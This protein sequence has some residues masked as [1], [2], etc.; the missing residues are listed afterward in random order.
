MANSK[1]G[2]S[3]VFVVAI[4][5][6]QTHNLLAKACGGGPR[7]RRPASAANTLAAGNK[8][9]PLPG[10]TFEC[11]LS[12]GADGRASRGSSFIVS[13]TAVGRCQCAPVRL[14]LGLTT[15]N[16]AGA[17]ATGN[18]TIA[19]RVLDG[20]PA[21]S[22]AHPDQ[23]GQ[24]GEFVLLFDPGTYRQV[25]AAG[26]SPGR[27]RFYTPDTDLCT[28]WARGRGAIRAGHSRD[29]A[30]LRATPGPGSVSVRLALFGH[31]QSRTTCWRVQFTI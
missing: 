9:R 7:W 15:S 24:L 17:G 26:A 11:H 16:P 12:T 20:G 23:A 10:A 30:H 21:E 18:K 14:R 3:V 28:V 29:C 2:T 25:G 13:A 1:F 31:T 27:A 19:A 5:F 4:V 22:E 8:C 6:R